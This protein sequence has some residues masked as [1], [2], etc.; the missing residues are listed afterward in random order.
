[1]D[2]VLKKINKQNVGFCYNVNKDKNN[3][4]NCILRG[5]YTIVPIEISEYTPLLDVK[6]R[7]EPGIMFSFKINKQ[8]KKE[9]STIIIYIE[10][11]GFQLTN[12]KDHIL[13]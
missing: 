1:M 7:L 11:K 2:V 12:I 5:N 4:D 3:L 8:L 13:E 10:S 9:L 6:N